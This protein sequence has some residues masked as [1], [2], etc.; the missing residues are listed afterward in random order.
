[1][2]FIV[3]AGLAIVHD[4]IWPTHLSWDLTTTVLIFGGWGIWTGWE[5]HK[6]WLR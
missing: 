6:E 4:I 1:M 3:F 2:K 5:W